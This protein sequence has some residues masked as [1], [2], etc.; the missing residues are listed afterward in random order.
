[1][2]RIETRMDHIEATMATKDDI[3]AMEGRLA[4]TIKQFWQQRPSH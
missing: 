3:A 1:M 2:D 4:D